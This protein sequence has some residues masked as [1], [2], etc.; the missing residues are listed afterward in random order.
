M[1][2]RYVKVLTSTGHWEYARLIYRT[3]IHW[4]VRDANGHRYTVTNPHRRTP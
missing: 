4:V 3:P 1:R 2:P